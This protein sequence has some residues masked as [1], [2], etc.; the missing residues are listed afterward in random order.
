VVKWW[1]YTVPDW[2]P[3]PDMNPG[4]MFNGYLI[5]LSY[6]SWASCTVVSRRSDSYFAVLK[7]MEDLIVAAEVLQAM[8][9]GPFSIFLQS[10]ATGLL[11]AVV[12]QKLMLWLL[13][14]VVLALVLYDNFQ[15]PRLIFTAVM[16]FSD[17]VHVR[18]GLHDQIQGWLH[19][20]TN[21]H[22]VVALLID[23]FPSFCLYPNTINV[24]ELGP[25]TEDQIARGKRGRNGRNQSVFLHAMKLLAVAVYQAD[26]YATE[27]HPYVGEEYQVV[28]MNWAWEEVVMKREGMVRWA[29]VDWRDK[30][31]Y[32]S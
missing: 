7:N 12:W 11:R 2:V 19:N 21:Y 8:T 18:I 31:F 20:A 1:G 32:G 3:K 6:R 17:S 13:A 23:D 10:E 9:P 29:G 15:S 4:P 24:H 14:P 26:F 28:A 22:L 30:V 27:H 25:L 16:R 5:A